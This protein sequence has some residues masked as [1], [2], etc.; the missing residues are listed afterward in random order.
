[1]QEVQCRWGVLHSLEPRARSP[2]GTIT[3]PLPHVPRGVMTSECCM[4]AF[5]PPN[6]ALPASQVVSGTHPEP[7]WPRQFSK[8]KGIRVLRTSSPPRCACPIGGISCD[9]SRRHQ[10]ADSGARAQL[11]LPTIHSQSSHNGPRCV[12]PW[13]ALALPLCDITEATFFCS[14]LQ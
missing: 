12:C 2:G 4:C 3:S 6:R 9:A 7:E 13:W 14:C 11:T 8:C 10:Q 1:M 5:V